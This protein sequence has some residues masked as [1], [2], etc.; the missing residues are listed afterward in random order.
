MIEEDR[1][2]GITEFFVEG[3]TIIDSRGEPILIVYRPD[4]ATW[5]AR[6]MN[7]WIAGHEK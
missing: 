2:T 6:C 3:G 4:D 5:I 1:W 7:F